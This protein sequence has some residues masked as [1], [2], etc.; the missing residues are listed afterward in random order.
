MWLW[1]E[2]DGLRMGKRR[3]EDKRASNLLVHC[4]DDEDGEDDV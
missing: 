4:Y 2:M 1:G 3:E